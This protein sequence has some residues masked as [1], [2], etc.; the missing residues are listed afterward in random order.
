M[1]T[2]LIILALICICIGIGIYAIP[3][4]VNDAS[5]P[6][7][8]TGQ[9]LIGGPFKLTNH[10]G[11][12]VTEKDFQGKYSLV[13]FGF[14]FCPDV[15]PT[16]LSIISQAMQLLGDDANN[17]TPVFITVDP[18]RD[19]PEQMKLYLSNFHPSIVG[20]TGSAKH[21][22]DVALEYKVYFSKV[23]DDSSALGYTMDHS[24]YTYLMDTEGKFIIHF[25]HNTEPLEMAKKL[26]Q[27][28]GS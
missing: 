19:T 11:E 18:E 2:R 27:K 21:I 6:S 22:E 24:A 20:L 23:K 5:K 28:L 3:A 13:Y 12:T 25:S 8:S 17:I 1:N 16:D 4:P 7:K 26:K 15:C 9:A 10:L 14:T